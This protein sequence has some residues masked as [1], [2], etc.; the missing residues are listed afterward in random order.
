MQKIPTHIKLH[1]SGDATIYLWKE[2][3]ALM[4]PYYNSQYISY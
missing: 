3:K 1:S 2:C 4:M